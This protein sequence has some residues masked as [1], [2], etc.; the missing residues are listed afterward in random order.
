MALT[1]P[2]PALLRPEIADPPVPSARRPWAFALIPA[3]VTLVLGL[4]G[5]TRRGAMWRDEAVTY[6]MAQRD[7]SGLLDTL[8]GVD[9]VHGL[10]YLLLHGVFGVFGDSLVALRLPSLLAM[11]AAA[12]GVALLGRRLAGPRA[13]LLA[14]L[15]FALLPA[16]QRYAQEGRSYALVC[17]AVIW[18][19]WLFVRALEERRTRLWAAYGVVALTGCLL[20]EFAV[21]AVA[22]H[23]AALWVSPDFR[24]DRWTWAWTAGAVAAALAPLAVVSSRQSEQVAWIGPPSP[25][26]LLGYVVPALAGLLGAALLPAGARLLRSLA[27]ALLILPGGLLLLS[28]AIVPLYVSRYV[29]Y[30]EA[31]LA[32]LL[33]ATLDHLWRRRYHRH[34]LAALAAAAVLVA[35]VPVGLHL[36]TPESRKDD[37]GAIARAV[38]AQGRPGDGLLFMPGRRRVWQ[39]AEPAAYASL[40]DLAVRA[41]PRASDT[42]YGV[43]LPAAAIHARMLTADRIVVLHDPAGEPVEAGAQEQVK[44][45]VLRAHFRPCESTE[46]RGARVTLY[47]RPGRCDP[48]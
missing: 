4:W 14:G 46:V 18:A 38:Q 24:R 30:E 5:L 16:V 10:Y 48:A 9:A 2:T 43:E 39:A 19:T 35:L 12:S 1:R 47:A 17:A 3:V 33:G 13:G 26:A 28:S 25:G 32:L 34:L 27:L 15:A 40:V 22:A 29:L 7:I 42:L 45:D 11:S 20:H 21:L 44:R 6:D 23:G 41:D 31:G 8:A 37:L 36:R